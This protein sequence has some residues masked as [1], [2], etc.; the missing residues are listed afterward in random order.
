MKRKLTEIEKARKVAN[1]HDF[2]RRHFIKPETC[3]FC[4]IKKRNMEWSNKN[5]KYHKEIR[6]EWQYLCRSCHSRYDFGHKL[7]K[8]HPTNIKTLKIILKYLSKD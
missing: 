2:V 8:G 5:H 7:R 6:S 1:A 4:G 3:E